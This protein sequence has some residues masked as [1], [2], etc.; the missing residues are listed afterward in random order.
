MFSWLVKL[1]PGGSYFN[2]DPSTAPEHRDSDREEDGFLLVGET[3]SERTTVLGNQKCTIDQPPAYSQI[4]MSNPV[5][6]SDTAS[7][8]QLT[9]STRNNISE[10]NVSHISPLS[11]VPFKFSADLEIIAKCLDLQ[12]DFNLP[13]RDI[14]QDYNYDF[15]FE[16]SLLRDLD[17]SNNGLIED[18]TESVPDL[19][20]F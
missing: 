3:L 1:K 16:K 10:R 4:I 9:P 14:F 17:Y 12:L 5:W 20:S 18:S 7:S 15:N 6:S 11:D 19:I 8:N 2:S 13:S